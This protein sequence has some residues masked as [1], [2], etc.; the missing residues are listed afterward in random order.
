MVIKRSSV[1]ACLL[2]LVTC[3]SAFMAHAIPD[4]QTWHTANGA[5]VL[6]VPSAD[7]PMVDIRVVF[8][9]GSAR[10]D[11]ISGLAALTNGLLAEGAGG[12]SAQQI[13]EN[14]ESVGA[15]FENDSLRDMALVGLRSLTEDVYLE[16]ALA[17]LIT[18]L[19]QPDFNQSAYERELARMKVA[20]EARKQSPASIADEAFFNALY[21][22]HPYATP[23]GG[24]EESLQRLDLEA[25]RAF[26]KQY[27]VAKNAVFVIVGAVHRKQAEQIVERI[28]A[29]M[30]P[31]KKAPPLPEVPELTSAQTIK[32]QFPSRQSHIYVGQTGMKRQDEDYLPLYIGNHSFGGSGFASRLV[33]KIREEHGLAYSVY[34]YFSPMREDGPFMMGM[35]TRAD[36]TDQALGLLK[37][38]LE[39]YIEEG[40]DKDEV[41]D[42]VGNI[43][44][45]FPLDLD[46]NSKLLGYLAMIGFYDLPN[47]Y[48]QTFISRVKAVDRKEIR[49]ALKRRILPDKMVTVIVGNGGE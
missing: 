29:G 21:G 22:G 13:A 15:V 49:D 20:V 36:Q 5:K 48:L 33:E 1:A 27:Y 17:T 44:G 38:E 10:D 23:P 8:D 7:L 37:T 2:A 34:S 46:S 30:A 40:P 31:G 18:V 3:I 42:S 12:L 35:Q 45:S 9:A 32:I 25:I 47:D 11:G 19:T 43:T 24:T 26:Y 4:I 41:A 14:F 16:K 28:S 6:F 39:K